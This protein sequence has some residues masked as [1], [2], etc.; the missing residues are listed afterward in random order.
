MQFYLVMIYFFNIQI[1]YSIIFMS[2]LHIYID[3][4][5]FTALI[6]NV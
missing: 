1:A 4:E 6:F 3:F 5:S 2:Q